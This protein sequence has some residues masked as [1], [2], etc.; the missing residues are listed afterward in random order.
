VANARVSV[1]NVDTG[2]ARATQTNDSG[3]YNLVRL[4]VGLY[5]VSV[6][7]AGFKRAK[8]TGIR[9]NVGAV[10]NLNVQLEIG[11]TQEAVTVSGEA[12]LIESTRSQTSTTV[13]QK[14]VSDLP[15]NGRNF[16]DF[17]LLTPGVVRDPRGGDLSF[18]GQ[19]GTANS[20]LV[21]GGDSNN[22]FFGQSTGRAGT[23]NP[24][25]FSQ[26]AVQEFQVNSSA[27]GA[28]TGR[29]GGGVINV[30]TKSGTNELH[31][32]AF[33]FYRDR[34]LNANTFINNSRG[35]ARQPFHFN[36][37]GGNLGGPVRRDKVFYFFNYDGQR[38]TNPNPVFLPVAA[39]ADTLSQQGARE[40]DRYLTPYTTN[41]N[42]NIYTGKIDWNL[43][44]RHN[45]NVR[46]NA[47]RFNGKNFE[48]AGS[49]SAAE[50][51]GDSNVTTDNIAVNYNRILSPALVSD[52]RVIY[53]RDDEPGAANSDAPEAQI[54]QN[55]ILVMQIGRNNFSPRYTN[56]KKTQILQS[57]SWIKGRHTFKFG[58]DLNFERIGN[59][60]PGN[61]SGSFQFAS[62]ADFA[63]RRATQL[64]QA[65]AGE[66]T[67]GP[68]TRPN[69]NEVA[70]YLQDA[71]RVSDRLT[72]NYGIRYDLMDSR[73]PLVR[74][75]DQGLAAMG[76]DTARMNLDSNNFAPR[77][78]FAYRLTRSNR[79]LL[80][81]GY[82][83]Y[84]GR[85]PAILTG[86]AHS[87]NGIQVQTYTIRENLPV[88][89]AVLSRPPAASRT[90]DI[91][92]FAPNYVQP[93]TH[94]WSLN[95]ETEVSANWLVTLG[96]LGV[97]GTHLTTT[98]DIN[99]FP[100]VAERGV[101]IDGSP[102]DVLRHPA[103]RPNRN[104]GRISLFDSGQDSIYH[105][106][107][108]QLTKRLSRSMQ[109]LT[110][111]TWSKVIDTVPEATSV[112]VGTGDDAKV[113]QD[114][115]L[116]GLDRGLG[117]SDIRHRF[118]FSGVWDIDYARSLTSPAARGILGGY[119]LSLIANVTSGRWFSQTVGG[120]SDVNRDG[121]ART[122][123][124]AGVGRNTIEGPGFAAV[125]LRF[126]KD[127]PVG[128]ERVRL[129]LIFEAFNL[130]NR[131][132]FNNFNRTPVAFNANTLAFTPVAGYLA[133]TGSA[134]PRI[135]Q[136][137]AKIIF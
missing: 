36:Q 134:D 102:I 55:N 86:T 69:V 75:P 106:G 26:D 64:T 99:L 98:R 44:D 42:N 65:F 73:D 96:Y 88:Y 52:T 127:V 135:L 80:R 25:S 34:A 130:T 28:E 67:D 101:W 23:R 38:N 108:V 131:A 90:P 136:L 120:T 43:S 5:E 94:Q 16:L 105:G 84:Y 123:R 37:F 112:V 83:I 7:S 92:A 68:L 39:P 121:N 103:T 3:L 126:S 21:D 56:S 22:L 81:G 129:R 71:W 35:I 66:G 59:F 137:A 110:S 10:V 9:L 72:V 50:H 30:V 29:A 125:D 77:F 111:Y 18:G 76:I 97:R 1:L 41:L 53:I 87:Q 58:G 4:P 51:T 11:A 133:R 54:R 82:G 6:E 17:A 61:F 13:N 104:F 122:D 48:N 132:N 20:L 57:A 63:A 89:P 40:L 107:F 2:L 74:N 100:S 118:V 45:L 49:Q 15:I 85:T 31:G 12:P 79:L 114:T 124:P 46:Y 62:Y 113:A 24:Y 95:V 119:Q 33:W 109:I 19:R 91:Y 32:T 27:Y 60:F 70:F 117:D 128:S 78:G 14:A 93:L 116:P 8:R 47:H 115:L